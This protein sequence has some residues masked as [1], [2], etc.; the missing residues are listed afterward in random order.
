MPSGLK[1]AVL[2]ERGRAPCILTQKT[3]L[4]SGLHNSVAV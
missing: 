2:L 1:E 4:L 3:E